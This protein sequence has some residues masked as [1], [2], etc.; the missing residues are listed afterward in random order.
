M[1]DPR[2]STVHNPVVSARRG[3]TGY[4]AV[5]MTVTL[6][7]PAT[8]IVTIGGDLHPSREGLLSLLRGIRRNRVPE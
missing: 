2:M 5:I 4:A 3:R 1:G 6:G 8:G 7:V